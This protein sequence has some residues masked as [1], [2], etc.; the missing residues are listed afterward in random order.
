MVQITGWAGDQADEK[1]R[2]PRNAEF[3][4]SLSDLHI[5]LCSHFYYTRKKVHPLYISSCRIVYSVVC[6]FESHRKLSALF[7]ADKST[8]GPTSYIK[9]C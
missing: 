5:S 6:T 3:S 2:L 1:V 4:G 8:P 7:I 9:K